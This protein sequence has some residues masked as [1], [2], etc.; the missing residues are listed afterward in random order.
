MEI[1][2]QAPLTERV[3]RE[4]FHHTSPTASCSSVSALLFLVERLRIPMRLVA[5]DAGCFPPGA[6]TFL[7]D[8]VSSWRY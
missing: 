1:I 7:A 6:F 4:R 2:L 3:A 5:A 8:I